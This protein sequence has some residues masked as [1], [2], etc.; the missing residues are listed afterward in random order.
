MNVNRY[1]S[2][3]FK[4]K[5]GRGGIKAK[6]HLDWVRGKACVASGFDIGCDAHHVLRKSQGLNDYA[7]VPLKHEIHMDVH[8]KGA[9]FV[10]LKYGIRMKDALIATLIERIWELENEF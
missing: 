2:T 9:H 5:V 4:L 10:E 8:S 7:V 1:F 6:R 3:E